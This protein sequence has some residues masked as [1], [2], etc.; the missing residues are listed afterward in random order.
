MMVRVVV[1]IP[2]ALVLLFCY[3]V[4]FVLQV[5]HDERLRP[6]LEA[7]RQRQGLG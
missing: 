1:I 4:F 2:P 7:L 3:F 5:P 6:A